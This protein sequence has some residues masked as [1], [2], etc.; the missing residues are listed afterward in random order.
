M[1]TDDDLRRVAVAWS[2]ASRRTRAG[3]V[4]KIADAFLDLDVRAAQ[5]I[6]ASFL[7]PC[8]PCKGTGG[9]FKGDRLVLCAVCGGDRYTIREGAR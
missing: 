6:T 9:G 2:R 4:R 7:V 3:V 1:L 5:R 8:A